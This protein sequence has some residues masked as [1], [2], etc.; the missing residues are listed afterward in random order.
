MSERDT[1]AAGSDQ[2]RADPAQAA[3]MLTGLETQASPSALRLTYVRRTE[4]GDMQPEQADPER[5]QQAQEALNGIRS[6]LLE[7]LESDVSGLDIERARSFLESRELSVT[8]TTLVLGE[9]DFSRLSERARR[10]IPGIGDPEGFYLPGVE[11]VAVRRSKQKEEQYGIAFIE[12]CLVH[13]WAH[14]SAG[15]GAEF[16]MYTDDTEDGGSLVLYPLR[17]GQVTSTL[18]NGI[19]AE[20]WYAEEGFADEIAFEYCRDVLDQPDGFSTS[21]DAII[22]E[23]EGRPVVLDPKYMI[24][25]SAGKQGLAR[26]GID[27][28]LFRQP[29][30]MRAM[31]QARRGQAGLEE[32]TRLMTDLDPEGAVRVA[33]DRTTPDS[34]SFART[35]RKLAEHLVPELAEDWDRDFEYANSLTDPDDTPDLEPPANKSQTEDEEYLAVY[36]GHTEQSRETALSLRRVSARMRELRLE[37]RAHGRDSMTDEQAHE[38]ELLEL[39]KRDLNSRFNQLEQNWRAD[40]SGKY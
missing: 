9:D 11:I 23:N 34:A 1:G 3:E 30:I 36:G 8:A 2:F 12:Y 4:A 22:M 21:D 27:M 6:E 39:E 10:L 16:Q 26:L 15:E 31:T 38:Y 20:G 28:I 5:I 7:G 29:D 14:A 13:E 19:Q 37:T 18:G 33:M 24:G 35:T 32:F 17:F 40:Q 25:E